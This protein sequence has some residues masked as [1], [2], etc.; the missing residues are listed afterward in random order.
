MN[1]SVLKSF[2]KFLK[3]YGHILIYGEMK[4]RVLAWFILVMIV[5]FAG[6]NISNA[7]SPYAVKPVDASE[8]VSQLNQKNI[9]KL[10]ICSEDGSVRGTFKE[11]VD[12]VINF[13]T[14][15]PNGSETFTQVY[16]D[17]ADTKYDFEKESKIV[18]FIMQLFLIVMQVGLIIFAFMLLFRNSDMLGD[19]PFFE[20]DDDTKMEIPDNSFAD[21]VG[22]PE[23]IE[24]VQEIV[25]FLKYPDMYIKAGAKFPRGIL[26]QGPPGSGKTLLAR[27]LAGEAGVPFIHSSGSEFIEMYVGVGAKRVRSLFEKARENQPSILFIDEIDAVGGNRDAIVN[28]SSEHLQTIN[29]LL[30]EMDGFKNT[31]TVIVIAATNRGESLDPALLRP[32]RFDRI[33]TVPN[34][35]KEGRKEILQHYAQGRPFEDPVDFDK[36]ASHTYGFSGAE[37]ESVMDQASILAARRVEGDDAVPSI[38]E[39][40]IDEAI[41][42]VISG[43]ALKS[44]KLSDKEK[45]YTSYHEAGHAVV[46]YILPGCD[47]VQKISIVSRNMPGVGVALGYVQSYSEEDSYVMTSEQMRDEIAALLAGRCSEQM[48]CHIETAG[49]S[50]DLERASLMAYSMVDRFAMDVPGF[51]KSFRVAV[52]DE[53]TAQ[54][55]VGQDRLNEIDEQVNFIL[56]E[57]WRKCT[58]V[59]SANADKIEKIVEILKDQETIDSDEICVIMEG[60][61]PDA[62]T[63]ATL[64]ETE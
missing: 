53:K 28:T 13:S 37:L 18:S 48:F 7:F 41:S 14:T 57:Q 42:R 63:E 20:K 16:L 12:G 49:A 54:P 44:K 59:I 5:L 43:P 24:E 51:D 64:E 1:D 25:S 50:N 30:T 45:E 29:Q 10:S 3:G 62:G 60:E 2:K 52:R 22:V 35:S 61:A 19:L 55:K 31:D 47:P 6:S 34:P 15:V 21:V 58:E 40:D 4:N 46:Q 39:K 36:L 9:E 38:S 26:L 8:F 32:G 11:P 27:C 17:A 33:I 23:A 56:N